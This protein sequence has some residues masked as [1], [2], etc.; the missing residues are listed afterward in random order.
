[1]AYMQASLRSLTILVQAA[2]HCIGMRS[3]IAGDSAY[4]DGVYVNF[5][6]LPGVA[7]DVAADLA[8]GLAV[9]EGMH[10]KETDFTVPDPLPAAFGHE[11]VN[12]I[13]D[14]RIE[15]IAQRLYPG[16]RRLLA[17]TVEAAIKI[18]WFSPVTPA[19]HP[20]NILAMGILYTL[21]LEELDQ[22][23]LQELSAGAVN[24]A[25]Q[26][27]GGLFD[28]CLKIAREGSRSDNTQGVADA[29]AKI[30]KLL[31]QAAQPPEPSPE[32][33]KNHQRKQDDS[34]ES[35]ESG[36]SGQPGNSEKSDKSD[37]PRKDESGESGKSEGDKDKSGQSDKSDGDQG[38][39]GQSG[40][41]EDDKGDSGQSG[42]PDGDKGDD[43]D[44]GN[45]DDSKGQSKGEKQD[46]S[47]KGQGSKGKSE[48]GKQDTPGDQGQTGDGKDQGKG[49]GKGESPSN[50]QS[51]GQTGKD[52]NTA[53][54]GSG[55][56]GASN[57]QGSGEA[58]PSEV[59]EGNA[60]AAAA[61]T[62]TK[63]D[64]S[65]SADLSSMIKKV[66]RR[67]KGSREQVSVRQAPPYKQQSLN[68]ETLIRNRIGGRLEALLVAETEAQRRSSEVGRL[69]SRRLARA[70]VDN[71]RIFRKKEQGEAI[72][73]A[74]CVLGDW[75]SSM[76]RTLNGTASLGSMQQ[77][78]VRAL[79]QVLQAKEIPLCV[80]F[81]NSTVYEHTA[82]D[83]PFD[84]LTVPRVCD[85][86]TQMAAGVYWAVDQL[87]QRHEK[88]RILVLLTDGLP[89]SVPETA[90]AIQEAHG[91]KIE[92]APVFIGF[93][94]PS[95]KHVADPRHAA[96][97]EQLKQFVNC[98]PVKPRYAQQ[99]HDIPNAMFGVLEE[100]LRN[101][102]RY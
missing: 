60:A 68:E 56:A 33:R 71:P 15:R 95:D 35:G 97:R 61:L 8:G 26:S 66:A 58:K 78:T 81:F 101:R 11:L 67:S 63:G 41:S 29:A 64:V 36:E 5:P 2:A 52:G 94:E 45:G 4:T 65:E 84:H 76:N 85:G 53:T 30:L 20:A 102:A 18:D 50:Q 93:S 96:Q 79:G 38:D 32:Q 43:K 21:R 80:G 54:T 3:R 89:G 86:T 12:L 90:A 98:F 83:A 51:Q 82:F 1:M 75:S 23:A 62:A 34:K 19:S 91:L 7:D 39:T 44:A 48:D 47:G 22:V 16:A 57:T 77:W 9:H 10:V 14:I 55:G 13:E 59:K 31:G 69:S 17:K 37:E 40:K 25:R 99:P 73:T 92:V 72:D 42:K 87:I 70:M 28:E 27:F 24:V 74:I 46:A 49:D 6:E 100:V 88:R